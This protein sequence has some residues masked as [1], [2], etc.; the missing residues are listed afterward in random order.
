[1]ATGTEIALFLKIAGTGMLRDVLEEEN[2]QVPSA[3]AYEPFQGFVSGCENMVKKTKRVNMRA[4]QTHHCEVTQ[5]K[6]K[7]ALPKSAGSV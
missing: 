4:C 3:D 2:G 7:S 5:T 1:M 6:T